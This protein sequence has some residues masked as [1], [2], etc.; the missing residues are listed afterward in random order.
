M[1]TIL[2][3]KGK[4]ETKY[5]AII[6]IKGYKTKCKTFSKPSLARKWAKPIE[7]QMEAGTY[8]EDKVKS[9]TGEAVFETISD[10]IRYF[11]E[12]E[13][14]DRYSYSEKYNVMY[15]WWDNKIGYLKPGEL[16]QT[17]LS[18]CKVLL[19]SE[20]IEKPLRGNKYR[21]NSTINKYLFAFSAIINY[22][23]EEFALWEYNPIHKIGKKKKKKAVKLRA[24]F[25]SED[26]IKKL[27]NGC[28]KKSY[29]LCLFYLLALVTGGRYSEVLHL[30]PE[31]ID[32]KNCRLHYLN[33][34]NETNRGV[35]IPKILLLKIKAF[36]KIREYFA[37]IVWLFIFKRVNEETAILS[38]MY[39]NDFLKRLKNEYL[40]MN[41]ATNKPYYIKGQLE[42]IIDELEIEDFR[43][44][45]IRHTSAS[46]FLMNGASETE[47]MELFGWN[48]H[49]MVRRYAHLSKKHTEN[50]VTKTSAVFL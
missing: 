23:I 29:M 5:K 46:Y 20:E 7:A 27:R 16:N 28:R 25:L 3:V 6:R 30:K 9:I 47:L 4:K 48:S 35:P 17:I 39:L 26:E 37:Y 2:P 43:I 50:L 11:K 10:L 15:D 41:F 12:H 49:T 40:F 21:S 38:E 8:K 34:K 18:E 14:S 42:K 36:L 13:A 22:G 24:R 33:T 44:H 19:G 45:D 1:A 31:N 32:F